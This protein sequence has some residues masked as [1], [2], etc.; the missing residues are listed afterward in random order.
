MRVLIG[1]FSGQ[2][3]KDRREAC[4]ETWMRDA[5]AAG[6]LAVFLMGSERGPT[7][8]SDKLHLPCPDAYRSLTMRT[9]AFCQWAL[10]RNDWDYLY[11][12]DDDTYVHI[13]RLL[14]YS[15][16][17]RDYIGAEWSPGVNYA[18]GGA[19]YLLSRAAAARI[20]ERMRWAGGA[21][22]KLVGRVLRRAKIPLHAEP[23]FVPFGRGNDSAPEFAAAMEAAGYDWPFVPTPDNDLI[24]THAI[25]AAEFYPIHSALI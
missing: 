13:D 5:K 3:M 2:N 16:Q 23:R 15:T 25:P 17:S 14:N 21:E 1:A 19:G 18:S 10:T 22:D 24:S 9:R 11:K 6:V 4:R 20:A 7:L 12:C 8:E